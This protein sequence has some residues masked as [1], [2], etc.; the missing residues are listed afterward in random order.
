MAAERGS[1]RYWP[2]PSVLAVWVA[3]V[4]LLV[5]ETFAPGMTAPVLSVTVPPRL[6]LAVACPQV[7]EL[8]SISI[9]PMPAGNKNRFQFISFLLGSLVKARC[10]WACSGPEP[11]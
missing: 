9:Q 1:K 5:I 2:A 8:V 10:N 11:L 4:S 7:P 6:A 3:P